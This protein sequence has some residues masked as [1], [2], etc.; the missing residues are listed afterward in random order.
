MGVT[1]FLNVFKNA[2]YDNPNKDLASLPFGWNFFSNGIE[3]SI[4]IVIVPIIKKFNDEQLL[5][6]IISLIYTNLQPDIS[7]QHD[8][9]GGTEKFSVTH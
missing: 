5:L 4:E 1:T 6:L 8:L 9:N 2:I 3:K 7:H